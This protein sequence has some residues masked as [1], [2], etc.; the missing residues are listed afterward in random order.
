MPP[1]ITYRVLP[2]GEPFDAAQHATFFDYLL[3]SDGIYAYA[4]SADLQACVPVAMGEL[5]MVARLQPFVHL[6]H[7]RL[8]VVL[9]ERMVDRFRATP[10]YE[11]VLSVVWKPETGEYELVEPKQEAGRWSVRYETPVGSLLEVHSHRTAAPIFSDT[12]DRDETGFRIYGV[13]GRLQDPTPQANFRVG[14][15][16]YRMSISPA[17]IFDR[18]DYVVATPQS[19]RQ[20][21][22]SLSG[23]VQLLAGRSVAAKAGDAR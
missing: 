17:E 7:G 4:G 14:V 21:L 3:A 19:A 11:V 1:I 16:G 5:R 6:P 13:I 22:A 10:D 15:H 12:D 2:V 8:P 20:R 9:Y 18:P 23:L